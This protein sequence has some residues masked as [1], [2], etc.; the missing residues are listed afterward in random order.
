MPRNTTRQSGSRAAAKER[1]KPAERVPFPIVGVGASAGGLEA[2]TELLK[3]LP[4]DTGM[5]FVLV[6]HLDPE[7]ESALT[8]LLS[9]ATSLPVQDA[10]NNRRVEPNRIYVIPRNTNLAIERGMLKLQPRPKARG[11]Q[12]SIDVFFESLAQDQRECAIGVILSGTATDGTLGLEAIKAEGGITFAQDESARYDSMPRSAAAA[13][14]VDFVLSPKNIAKELARIAKHPYVAGARKNQGAKDD[15]AFATA[16]EDDSTAQPSGARAPRTGVREARAEATRGR[17]DTASAA[18]EGYQKIVP[19][20]H[21]HSGVDF[22]LYKSSTIQRRIARRMLLQK[23]NTLAGYLQLLRGNPKELDALY[24]DVLISVTSFFRDPES[25][26]VLGRKVLSKLLQQRTDEPLRVWVPGCS[27][28]QEAYSIAMA[29]VEAAG[30]ASRTRRLQ[31]FATDLNDALLAKARHGLYAKTLANDV[32]PE[33]LRRFF[34]EED[35]GYRVVKPLREMVVFARQNALSDPPFS[36]MDLISCRNLLIYLEP[37]LQKRVLPVFH[38]ALKPGGFL[39]LGRSEST[40]GFSDLFEPVDKKHKIYAKKATAR[41]ALRLPFINAPEAKSPHGQ[42]SPATLRAVRREAAQGWRDEGSAQREA[43]RVTIN[44]FA[45]PGVLV[46]A[47][48]QILQFRGPTSAYLEPPTGKASFDVL[49]MARDGL[50]VP[51]RAAIHKAKKE[52]RPARKENVRVQQNGTERSVNLEVVPLKNLRERCFLILFEDATAM[53]GVGAAAPPKATDTRGGSRRERVVGKKESRHVAELEAE[54]VETRAYLQSLQEQHEAAHED[55]QA[56]N[57][58]VQSSNEEL[59]S[60]NEELEISKEELESTNEELT[61]INEEMVNRNAELGRLYSDLINVQ[62]STRLA[63]VLLGRDLAIRSFSA[64]AGKRLNLVATDVGRSFG[65]IRHNLVVA[66]TGTTIEPV[67]KTARASQARKG[68]AASRGTGKLPATRAPAAPDLES[69]IAEVISSVHERDAEVRDTQ[70]HWYSV[71]VRPY[72]TFDNKVD[73]AVLVLVD[74]D[75]L[76]RIGREVEAARDYAE[77][78][79]R[80]ART[81]LVVLRADLRVNTANEAFYNNFQATPEETL[82]R[83]M[84]ELAGGAWN[85]AKLRTLLEEVLPR[86]AVF[87]D[88]EVTQDFPHIGRRTMLLNARRLDQEEGAQQMILLAIEDVTTDIAGTALAAIVNSSSDAIIGKSISGLITSWNHGAEELFGYTAQEAIGQPITMLIPP[89]RLQEESEI[90]ERLKRGERMDDFETVRVRK[91]GSRVEVSLSISPVKD[92]T[93]EVVGAAKIARDITERK[94]AEEALREADRQKDRFIAVLAHEL[95]GPL[96]PLSNTLEILKRAADN[97]LVRQSSATMG[98]HLGQMTRLID[99]LLDMGRISQGKLELRRKTV[100]LASVIH[101]AVE[102]C[103]AAIES[104]G[105]D[106]VVT[107][108][109]RPTYLNA[110]SMRLAQVFGNLLSNASKYSDRGSRIDLTAEQ[111]GGEVVVSVK[112]NGIGIPRGM[113]QKI[114]DMFTQVDQ[115]LERTRGGLG[116]GLTLVRQLV[117]LHGGSIQALSEGPGRGS[118]FVVR[119]PVLSDESKLQPQEAITSATSPTTGRRILVVDDDRDAAGSLATLLQMTGNETRI[120]CDGLEAVHAA[121]TFKPDVVLLD[122]GMPKLNGYDACRRIREQ[123]WGKDMVLIALTGW[124]QEQ[125]RQKSRDA[126]FD[127]HLVKPVDYAALMKMLADSRRKPA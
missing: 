115:S 86:N 113:L 44:Q 80:T 9:R 41:P 92:A 2:F 54:L 13:G 66:E 87:N 105:Q 21:N 11:P 5:G 4:L 51:L 79:V 93:G 63:I 106:L 84:F 111:R 12:R 56:A 123:P 85:I 43:D 108:P 109:R 69:L 17:G 114:F 116:I 124:G 1:D 78:T 25:F 57:E 83:P 107:L 88:F 16:R 65:S 22:S 71:R 31:V 48:L 77:A 18:D 52:N 74:I 24:A 68:T 36:R 70:G 119:L 126:G 29:A 39:F 7:H 118:E 53:R 34:V 50:M 58:E 30:K 82:G 6:Q 32:S 42:K 35:G 20:L 101:Q 103:R 46:N 91:D 62:T 125:D 38:Y 27:T 110:D 10:S 89:E 55:L 76:K 61:T 64:E 72:F 73:G 37:D 40:G 112:D 102:A 28:G 75:E 3:H 127:G 90:V 97:E 104:A 45:P 122:I 14:C 19:L 23:Q 26:D 59:Q 95:R 120:A 96:A 67:G 81:P 47:E 33:R 99:D 60:I 98:R 8:Q 121:E 49:K 15:G 100:E 117:E 94:R